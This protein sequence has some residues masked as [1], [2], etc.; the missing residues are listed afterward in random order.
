MDRPWWQTAVVYQIYPRSFRDGDGDGVGDLA[1]ITEKLGYLA[2][3]GVGAVWL[4][5]FYPS[6]QADFGYDVS[7]YRGVDPQYG[8][9][10]D[11]DRL[12]ARAHDLGLKLIVD[13][14]PNH[15]SDQHPWFVESRQSRD[16]PKRDW[17]VWRDP[18]PDGSPPNNWLSHFG[19]PAWTLD[20]ATGQSY[21][22]SFLKEQPDLNWRNPAVVDE[23]MD[24]LRF[25]MARGVDGFRIDVAHAILK[26][27]ELRDN[28]LAEDAGGFHKPMGAYDTLVHVHDKAHPDVHE[29]FARFR[30]TVDG[31][32]A[33]ERVTIGEIHEYDDLGRWASYY[34]TPTEAGGLSGLHMPF[35]FGLLNT[36]WTAAGVRAHVDAIEAVLPDGA[37]PN[38]VLGNHD[39]RRLATRLGPES[40]CLAGMLLLTLRGAPTLY[41][42]DE[43]GMEEVDVPLDRRVDPW[44]FRSGVPELGRDGCRTPMAWDAS[45]GAGFSEGA[46]P[47]DY[48]LPLH[49]DHESVNVAAEAADPDSVLSFYR[50]ALAV[51]N[52]SP[53]LQAGS[54]RPLDDVPEGVFGFERAE[55]DDRRLVLLHFGDDDV[56]VAVPEAYRGAP[57]ALATHDREVEPVGE[58]FCLGPWAGAVVGPGLTAGR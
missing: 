23:M 11:F 42:G 21:L 38:Y 46:G 20:E 15:S 30:Q 1:G 41:Y 26:D 39:E 48:W 5:P 8:T 51:R 28:P 24:T 14:V 35:N 10:D 25:W 7:D 43:L 44:G 32:D 12:A 50:R 49:P 27:P 47:S 37:W 57:V 16:N 54:Y 53:A 33:Q 3:L 2:D 55:G 13:F 6:P 9:L 58:V 4:S 29:A 22:H 19:G 36:P 45:P 56:E 40:V 34:G 18:K 17:Y 31:F 52:A